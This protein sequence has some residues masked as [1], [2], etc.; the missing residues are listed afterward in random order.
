MVKSLRNFTKEGLKYSRIID[1]TA[2]GRS[3]GLGLIGAQ[4]LASQVEEQVLANTSTFLVGRSH[5]VEIKN[6][7]YEWLKQGLK[8]KASI[9]PKGQMFLW[10]AV[11]ARPALIN[12]PIPLHQLLE[13]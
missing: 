1:I 10:H 9:L 3:Y 12:F 5:A 4:Q 2:R 8:E 11:H 13:E 6:R 7:P